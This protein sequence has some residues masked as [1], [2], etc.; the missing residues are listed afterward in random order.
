[1]SD[2]SDI[3]GSPKVLFLDRTGDGPVRASGLAQRIS[4]AMRRQG[5]DVSGPFAPINREET[6]DLLGRYADANCLF[7]LAAGP[8]DLSSAPGPMPY[9]KQSSVGS[10]PNPRLVTLYTC[11]S[12]Q[13]P[14]KNKVVGPDALAAVAVVSKP[15]MS[16]KEAALFFPEFFGELR[17]HCADSISLAMVRFCFA[18]A[19]RLAPK[20]AEIWTGS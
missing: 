13:I 19:D 11:Q 7:L 2:P 14:D 9:S 18:K 6:S 4:S 12:P 20:K 1:M 17:T 16:P 10:P 15:D 8:E 3:P 5:V